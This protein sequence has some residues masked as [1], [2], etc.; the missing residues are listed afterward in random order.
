MTFNFNKD[1]MHNPKTQGWDGG[2]SLLSTCAKCGRKHEGKC[3]AGLILTLIV[4]RL[5][6]K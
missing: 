3:L 5:I 1:R 6:T 2:G 4:A